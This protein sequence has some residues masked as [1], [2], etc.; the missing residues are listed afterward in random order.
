M[1]W[2][3]ELLRSVCFVTLWTADCP[4]DQMS[5]VHLTELTG[6]TESKL[7]RFFV[8]AKED[9]SCRC[10][11]RMCMCSITIHVIPLLI[12]SCACKTL[13]PILQLHESESNGAS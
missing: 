11:R 10:C 4:F 6:K 2:I 12:M 7:G 9:T 1:Q 3:G 5:I 8:Y 13:P